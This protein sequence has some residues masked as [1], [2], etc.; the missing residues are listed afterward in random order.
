MSATGLRWYG[1]R[2]IRKL[3]SQVERNM[4]EACKFLVNEVK[5]SFPDP[6]VGAATGEATTHSAPG[7]IPFVQ[8]NNLRCSINYVVKWTFFKRDIKGFVGVL[9]KHK[10]DEATRVALGY[11]HYLEFGTPGGKIAARPYLRPAPDRNRG[12]LRALLTRPMK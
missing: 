8:L 1:D 6:R 10:G 7:G 4:K 9:K 11:A 2:F 12:R 5:R 3:E